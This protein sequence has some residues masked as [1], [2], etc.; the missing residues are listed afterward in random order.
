MLML[1]S[2]LGGLRQPALLRQGRRRR[3]RAAAEPQVPLYELEVRA[4]DPLRRLLLDY[5]DL[6]RFQNA[7]ASEAITPAE[8]ERLAAAAPA[9]ARSLLET[10]GYFDA[11]VKVTR[12]DGAAGLPRIEV[13]VVPGPRVVVRSVAIDSAAPLAPRTPTRDEPW[14]DRLDK[15]RAI[16]SLREGEPFR[17]PDWNSAKNAALGALA[18]RR[19]SARRMAVDERAHRCGRAVGGAFGHGRARAAVPPRADPDRGNAPLR[20]GG[21]PPRRA[22]P[23]PAASTARSGCSTSRS[24]S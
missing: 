13:D 23:R 14:R 7:P 19:L 4:P 10:E 5:L 21:D 12:S 9:Q 2:L 3:R 6:A 15:L 24:A 8:L 20:R 11:D 17:Q 18:R 16:W 22:A 1:V